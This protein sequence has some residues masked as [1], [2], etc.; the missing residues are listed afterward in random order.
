MLPTTHFQLKSPGLLEEESEEKIEGKVGEGPVDSS[1]IPSSS[2]KPKNDQL[3]LT[4]AFIS[5]SGLRSLSGTESDING[6]TFL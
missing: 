6:K 4:V 1:T 2:R 3:Y 5:G